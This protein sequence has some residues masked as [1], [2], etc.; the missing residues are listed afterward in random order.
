M[1][2]LAA[3]V[4]SAACLA[5]ATSALGQESPFLP[6]D[7]YNKLTNEISGDIAFENLRALLNDHVPTGEPHG[8]PI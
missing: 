5:F 7:T 1:R 4:S 6:E 8:F 3:F 2:P